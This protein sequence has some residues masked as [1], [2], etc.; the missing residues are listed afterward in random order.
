MS[1]F[2]SQEP[3]DQRLA[4]ESRAFLAML[5]AGYTL[6]EAEQVLQASY[7]AEPA[8]QRTRRR[9]SNPRRRR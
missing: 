7:I 4:S 2:E 5:W 8:A 3:L 9:A 6:A 1:P